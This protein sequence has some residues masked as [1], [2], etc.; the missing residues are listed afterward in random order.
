VSDGEEGSEDRAGLPLFAAGPAH[1][2]RPARRKTA[3]RFVRTPAR[4][5]L[6]IE[7]DIP[8]DAD[9]TQAVLDEIARHDLAE[10]V[11]RVIYDLPG[12]GPDTVDLRAVRAALTGAFFVSSISRKPGETERLRR[13]SV[14]EETGLQEA[15]ARYVDNNPGL[16][17]LKEDLLASA[18]RLEQ[19]LQESEKG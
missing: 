11:V 8:P 4:P 7:L 1:A 17:R 13:S 12:D 16:V 19:E 10:A 18:V 6:T 9:P 14:S 5:F 3:Y 15:L 2:A